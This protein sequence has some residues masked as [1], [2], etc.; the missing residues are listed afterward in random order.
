MTTTTPTF[1]E[2]IPLEVLNNGNFGLIDE[3]VSTDFV[4]RTP[5]PGVSPTRDGFKQSAIAM[6]TAFLTCATR[7]R[8]RSRA[9]TRSSIA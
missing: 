3:L 4:D 8:T 5:Q 6:K 1:L 7:W 9:A 2:R